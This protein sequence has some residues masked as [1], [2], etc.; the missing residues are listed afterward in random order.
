MRPRN[1]PGATDQ[2]CKKFTVKIGGDLDFRVSGI[3]RKLGIS[4]AD[5][6]LNLVEQGVERYGLDADLK[7]VYAKIIAQTNAAA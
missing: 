6:V 1:K 3:A 2:H 7:A 5:F 4:K